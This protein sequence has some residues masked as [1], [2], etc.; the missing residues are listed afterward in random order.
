[1]DKL[2]SE[3]KNNRVNVSPAQVEALMKDLGIT[4]ADLDSETI[5]GLVQE[6]KG[7]AS[8]SATTKEVKQVAASKTA[9]PSTP[10]ASGRTKSTVAQDFQNLATSADV[11]TSRLFRR[12]QEIADQETAKLEEE[13]A[14]Q[15]AQKAI[16]A[17]MQAFGGALDFLEENLSNTAFLLPAQSYFQ[18]EPSDAIEVEATQV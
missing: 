9:A 18:L 16:A 2:I 6:L 11:A 10:A 8:S 4:E 17:R 1:M 3:L 14:R 13:L 5:A 15:M 12:A 7:Q